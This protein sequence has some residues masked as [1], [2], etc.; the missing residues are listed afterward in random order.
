MEIEKLNRGQFLKTLGMSSKALMA[1]Y[2]IGAVS[3]C[4]SE[5]DVT[6]NNG[7]NT[8][9]TGN[10]DSGVTGT[11]SGTTIDFTVDL[12]NSKNSKLLTSGEFAIFG[13]VLV[14][15]TGSNNFIA[16]SKSCTH[17]GTQLAYRKTEGD[18]FCNNHGS[19]FNTDGSVKKSPA[20]SSLKTYSAS[21]DAAGNKLKVS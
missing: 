10:T 1:F 4:S 2:C 12:S 11:T 16:V 5:D 9:T 20:E 18:L 7:N 17:Q 21:F 14:A 13:N 8:G 3:A 19:L 6:P 15:N